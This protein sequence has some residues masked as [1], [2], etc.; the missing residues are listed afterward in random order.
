M[1]SDKP[2]STALTK[3]TPNAIIVSDGE[4]KVRLP[5]TKEEAELLNNFVS[6]KM[7]NI[8]LDQMKRY[9]DGDVQFTPK[10]IKDLAEAA[11]GIR[12]LTKDMIFPNDALADSPR[13]MKEAAEQK[14]E[15]DVDFSKIAEIPKV[16]EPVN[17]ASK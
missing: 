14:T 11:K 4:E 2:V 3:L 6:S 9:K 16:V 7:R 15:G 1:A 10:E 8:L 13:A 12:E 17:I 5:G